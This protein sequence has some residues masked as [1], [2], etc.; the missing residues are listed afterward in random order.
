M[1]SKMRKCIVLVMVILSAVAYADVSAGLV[2]HWKLDETSG[3]TAY[4]STGGNNATLHNGPVWRPSGGKFDGALSFDEVDDYI[5][6]TDFEYT[7]ASDEFSLCFWFRIDDITGAS[8]QYLFSHG[9]ISLNNSLNV[10]FIESNHSQTD[11]AGKLRTKL[12]LDDGSSWYGTTP[13]ATLAD[14]IWHM[15]AITLS[16]V[17]GTSI[18]I[19]GELATA[20]VGLKGAFNPAT[21]IYLGARCDLDTSRYYGNPSVDDGLL[22]DLRIYDYALSQAEIDAIYNAVAEPFQVDM[23]NPGNLTAIASSVTTYGDG[24][25]LPQYAVNGAGLNGDAHDSDMANGKMW[26]TDKAIVN[27]WFRVDLG[28]SYELDHMKVWNFNW[29]GY[30]DRG[31]NQA[32]IY[33]SNAIS[34]PGN[35]V[36]DPC[37][38][39]L[40]GTAGSQ[41]FTKASGRS[42]YGTNAAYSMPDEV[43]LAGIT[44]NWVAFKVNSNHG[45]TTD[46]AV[47][48]SEVQ[49]FAVFLSN[50][51]GN[52]S[53]PDNAR[54]VDKDKD[55]ILRWTPGVDAVTHDVYFGTDQI[56]VGDANDSSSEYKGSRNLYDVWYSPSGLELG[57]TYYWRIDE[58][59]DAN[60]NSPWKGSVW[61]FATNRKCD[62]RIRGDFNWDC[63]I[64][65]ED[66]AFLSAEWFTS[67]DSIDL[68]YDGYVDI[69]DFADFVESWLT[70]N[71]ADNPNCDGKA[72]IDINYPGGNILVDQVIGDTIYVQQDIRDT[73]YWWFYWNFRVWGAEGRTLAF[74]F[75]NGNPIGLRG[76]AVSTDL[77][78][79][80]S[81]MGATGGPYFNYTFAQGDEEVQF[82]FTIP[83]QESDLVQFLDRHAGDPNL[84]IEEHCLTRK[85][86]SVRR[87]FLGKLDGEPTYRVQLTCRHHSCE[88][89]ASY[90]LEGILEEILA[91]TN[92]GQWFRQ[93]VEVLAIPFMDKDGVEDGDQGK[94][95]LPHDHN[96]DYVGESI[97]PSVAAIREFVPTWSNGK[98]RL[99]LDMHSPSKN[100]AHIYFYVDDTDPFRQNCMDFCNILE[101]G[102]NG[103]LPYYVANNIYSAPSPA[104]NRG[105]SSTLPGVLVPITLEFPYATADGTVV[106]AESARAFGHDIAHAIRQYL[107][108]QP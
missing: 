87:L 77:G 25:R 37:N 105:W 60:D 8:C 96:R 104:M 43:H 108:Q 1:E 29:A 103:P 66:F 89:T 80:W 36:D 10:Y 32:D 98:L 42:D 73:G 18:Y 76:P 72:G 35:P 15:Y 61:S 28:N 95:R 68:T 22:D 38:W 21:S 11:I 41:T 3:S 58:V 62:F 46:G 86:R 20:N 2:G 84:F 63:Y 6:T 45:A 33:F 30:V 48:L 9:N 99:T 70:C 14:G 54:N 79:T 74:Q 19:D 100:D 57:R 59:N 67:S 31:V 92:D 64:D 17:D 4:N 56:A 91:D 34:D 53:P 51:A 12:V 52:P 107:Q 75:T 85:G 94:G 101:L 97:Y 71:D 39:T 102:R 88:T 7:N 44:A 49:F 40:I 106:T 23:I 90:V 5:T 13:S 50:Y 81:W 83:Y 55:V 27:E 26:N 78:E 24:T 69:E 93:N 82:C 65:I 16:S 47:G